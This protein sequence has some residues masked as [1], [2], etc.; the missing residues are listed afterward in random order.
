MDTEIEILHVSSHAVWPNILL[1]KLYSNCRITQEYQ[2]GKDD[3]LIIL[4]LP[5]LTPSIP[6]MSL[7]SMVKYSLSPVPE[8]SSRRR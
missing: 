6:L 4:L 8:K 3:N 7:D 2:E 1:K 5:I